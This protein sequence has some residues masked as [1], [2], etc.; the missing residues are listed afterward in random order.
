MNSPP[1]RVLVI[2]ILILRAMPLAAEETGTSKLGFEHQLRRAI[3]VKRQPMDR[4]S[5][6]D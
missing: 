1:V 6:S 3:V 2:A 5:I 4:F